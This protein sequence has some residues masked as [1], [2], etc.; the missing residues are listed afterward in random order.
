MKKMGLMMGLMSS[1][2]IGAGAT[3]YCMNKKQADCKIKHMLND[4][5]DFL[6]NSVK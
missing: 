1:A 3:W 2:L 5:A 6:E 4:A